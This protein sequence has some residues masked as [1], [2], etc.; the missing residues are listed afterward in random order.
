[1]QHR[2]D[3]SAKKV[4]VPSRGIRVIDSTMCPFY[5]TGFDGFRPLSGNKGYRFADCGN[6]ELIEKISFRPLSGNKGYRS[7]NASAIS[8]TSQSF[9]PLSG[10]K[11]YR[12]ASV[13]HTRTGLHVVS[14]PSRGIRVIDLSPVTL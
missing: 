6:D 3:I 7:E 5:E 11:G 2:W 10:N 4:S 12:S 8:L 1:M 13:M 9:R 14:V